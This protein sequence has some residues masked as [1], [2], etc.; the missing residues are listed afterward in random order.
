MDK[1]DLYTEDKWRGRYS[2]YNLLLGFSLSALRRELNTASADQI[3]T[4]S[5][6]LL[7]CSVEI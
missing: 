1:R 6:D 5:V 4:L 2:F 7:N 3:S